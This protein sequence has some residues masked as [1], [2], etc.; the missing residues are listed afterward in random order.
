MQLMTLNE[1]IENW[2][3]D[4]SVDQTRRLVENIAIAGQSSRNGYAYA[5]DALEQAVALYDGKPVF[6]DHAV[7]RQRP[8]ERSTRDLVGSVVNPRFENGR[9][10]GDIQVLDTE[11]GRTFLRLV[12]AE[13]PGVGM[14][15]VVL[16]ERSQ[17]GTQVVRIAQVY[18]VDA[19][20]N[21]ATTT[22]FSESISPGEVDAVRNE[23]D[24]LILEVA[25]LR[26]RL[27][28]ASNAEDVRKLVTQSG[29]APEA[30]SDCFFEQLLSTPHLEL[31][32]KLIEDRK[33]L[34]SRRLSH[35]DERLAESHTRLRV[36]PTNADADDFLRV[37]K[38]AA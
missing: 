22:T 26:N 8:L 21:P 9:I 20:I 27:A 16:A 11:S 7:S 37:L 5:E 12:E 3:S 13:V 34:W 1:R 19:V 10:R 30:V 4:L 36:A 23:R 31:R 35:K 6:L 38:R 32:R 14:S 29:L 25:H 28:I 2:N 24:N 33:Q 17:D 18:S 15:H